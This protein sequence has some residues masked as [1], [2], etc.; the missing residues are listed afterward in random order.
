MFISSCGWT[1]AVSSASL[2]CHSSVDRMEMLLI[3]LRSECHQNC[4]RS[5]HEANMFGEFHSLCAPKKYFAPRSR[6]LSL[7]LAF[8][9]IDLVRSVPSQE[10][11]ENNSFEKDHGTERRSAWQTGLL[12]FRRLTLHSPC[13]SQPANI[14]LDEKGHTKISDLGLACDLSK[15]KPHASV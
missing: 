14:L 11:F 5:P 2:V 10:L 8:D 9:N 3:S 4:V 7:V 6:E 13:Y 12:I 1:A 15:K